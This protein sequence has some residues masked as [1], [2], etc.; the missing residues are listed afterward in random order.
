VAAGCGFDVTVIDGRAEWATQSRFPTSH[1]V[2]QAADDFARALQTTDRDFV[3]I[4][5]H[6]HALD[7]RLVQ[8]LLDRPCRF[9]GMVGSIPKQR[10]FAL[11]LKARGFSDEQIAVLRSP[12]GLPIGAATPEEIAVSV[13]AELIA[14]RR[15]ATAA[16]GWTPGKSHSVRAAQSGRLPAELTPEEERA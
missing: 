13:I 6:D 9:L 15:G 1:V 11:R 14:V 16:P 12:L 4:V 3:V 10:K 2:Q 5:T 8:T 7:Q